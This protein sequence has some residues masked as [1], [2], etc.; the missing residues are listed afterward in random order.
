MC[1]PMVE[2]LLIPYLSFPER[3]VV[4][5]QV[6]NGYT[7][8][9]EKDG[10]DTL[11]LHKQRGGAGAGPRVFKSLDSVTSFVQQFNV[12]TYNVQLMERPIVM[13]KSMAPDVSQSDDDI[14]F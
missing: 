12:K 8:R 6:E 4:A 14:P 3:L 11:E 7:I 1:V 10:S 13:T 5:H 2:R 9:I